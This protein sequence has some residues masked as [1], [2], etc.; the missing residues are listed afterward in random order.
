MARWVGI[1]VLAAAVAV[2]GLAAFTVE[3]GGSVAVSSELQKAAELSELTVTAS[4]LGVALAQQAGEIPD[5]PE[6]KVAIRLNFRYFPDPLPGK[7]LTLWTPKEEAAGLWNECHCEKGVP[8]P[9]DQPI[10]NRTVFLTPGERE[11]VLVMLVFENPVPKRLE[12]LA[13]IPRSEPS[14]PETRAQIWPTCFCVAVPHWVPPEGGWFRVIRLRAGPKLE[15]GIKVDLT[16]TVLTDPSDF[17]S[18]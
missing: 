5:P 7:A 2:F 13:L 11:G 12:W 8:L 4:T 10:P 1:G 17:K 3:P 15:P 6:G 16:W 18:E 9:K 14:N